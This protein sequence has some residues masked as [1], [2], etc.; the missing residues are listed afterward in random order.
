[1]IKSGRPKNDINKDIA[2]IKSK[3]KKKICNVCNK[4]NKIVDK[5]CFSPVH[6]KCCKLKLGDIHEIGKDKWEWECLTYT[7]K[8][9]LF[10]IVED[11]EI[12]KNSFNSNFHCKCQTTANFDLGDSKFRFK[13]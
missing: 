12:I 7:S 4:K 5:T 10:T 1:M 13:F 6:R 8:K 9:F 3:K 11:K 2:E